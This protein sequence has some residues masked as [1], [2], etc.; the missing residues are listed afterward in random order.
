VIHAEEVVRDDGRT[1]KLTRRCFVCGQDVSVFVAP[2]DAE[3]FLSGGGFAQDI[4]PY[5]SAA[6]RELL[7]SGTCGPCFDKIFPPDED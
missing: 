5:L 2:Q 4:F 3:E 7:I 1:R 6:D